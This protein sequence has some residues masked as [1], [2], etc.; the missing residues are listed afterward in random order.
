MSN[1]DSAIVT[2]FVHSINVGKLGVEVN[3]VNPEIKSAA[4]KERPYMPFGS[5]KRIYDNNVRV[6]DECAAKQLG[7]N[8]SWRG[9]RPR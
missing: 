3:I 6:R 1:K 5:L 7:C 8:A 4:P 9:R 2:G